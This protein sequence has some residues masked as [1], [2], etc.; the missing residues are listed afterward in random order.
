MEKR[1]IMLSQKEQAIEKEKKEMMKE[2]LYCD[3]KVRE[4]E[5]RTVL[6]GMVMQLEAD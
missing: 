1:T 3:R 6:D 2:R 4:M 5:C